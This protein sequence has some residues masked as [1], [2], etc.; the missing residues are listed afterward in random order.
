MILNVSEYYQFKLRLPWDQQFRVRVTGTT[1]I[2]D[3]DRYSDFDVK[4]KFFDEKKIGVASYLAAVTGITIYVVNKI[5]SIDPV[6]I[7]EKPILIPESLIDASSVVRLLSCKSFRLVSNDIVRFY[8]GPIEENEEQTKLLQQLNTQAREVDDLISERVEF[9]VENERE[10]I[11]D[12]DILQKMTEVREAELLKRGQMVISLARDREN[13]QNQLIL[14]QRT[15]K[16]A[17]RDY[18]AQKTI[19]LQKIAEAEAI[20]ATNQQLNDGLNGVK[21]IIIEIMQRIRSG[22]YQPSELPSFEELYNQVLNGN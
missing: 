22:T 7:E 2:E 14:D 17:K 16:E 20:R 12:E 8:D 9:V 15:A 11:Y 21:S 5:I 19:L 1:T 3:A 4:G 10:V 18:D 13:E 6:T